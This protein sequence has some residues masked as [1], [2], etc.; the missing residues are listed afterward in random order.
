ML[1]VE[2][3]GFAKGVPGFHFRWG[4]GVNRAHKSLRGGGAVRKRAQLT[5]TILTNEKARVHGG[6]VL[7]APLVFRRVPVR[8]T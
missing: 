1:L 3:D 6:M 7:A 5:D 8:T 2:G 4:V